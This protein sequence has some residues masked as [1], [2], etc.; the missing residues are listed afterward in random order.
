MKLLHF[1][2]FK[3]LYFPCFLIRLAITGWFLVPL[4]WCV[5]ASLFAIICDIFTPCDGLFWLWKILLVIVFFFLGACILFILVIL[6]V[7][8]SPEV[9]DLSYKELYVSY[10][11]FVEERSKKKKKLLYK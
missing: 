4:A 6:A 11:Q 1:I 8:I 9:F 3:L 7:I 2:F 10:K 5:F